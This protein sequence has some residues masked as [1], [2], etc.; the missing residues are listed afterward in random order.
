LVGEELTAKGV[1]A[2][3]QARLAI[4]YCRIAQGERCCA[5]SFYETKL[6]WRDKLAMGWNREVNQYNMVICKKHTESS[7]K[8]NDYPLHDDHWNE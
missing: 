3:I 8:G 4:I 1:F 2:C 6:I 7:K 5:L